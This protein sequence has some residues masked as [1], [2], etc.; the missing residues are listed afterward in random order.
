VMN[1]FCRAAAIA[2]K[3][4][5]LFMDDWFVFTVGSLGGGGTQTIIQFKLNGWR[6]SWPGL[7]SMCNFV[8][9][10]STL[11]ILRFIFAVYSSD[12]T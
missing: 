3:K 9:F 8:C 1:P 5:K 11:Y 4:K 2:N 12:S 7:C 10:N 6:F